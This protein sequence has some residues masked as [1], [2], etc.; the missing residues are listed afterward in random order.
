[1]G[2]TKVIVRRAVA[3][4]LAFLLVFSLFHGLNLTVVRAA[5]YSEMSSSDAYAYSGNDLGA[6]YSKASTTFKV[7]AP[8]ASQVQLKRYKTGSDSEAG[9][10]VISVAEMTKEAQ[11]IWSITV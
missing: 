8:T 3:Q 6:T 9:A 11:G 10:G 2:K 4:V 5:S 1:M 7:W